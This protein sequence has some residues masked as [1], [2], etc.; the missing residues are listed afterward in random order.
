M[1]RW[2]RGGERGWYG[3]ERGGVGWVGNE[4]GN[5]NGDGET[6]CSRS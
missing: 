3:E 6:Y 2:G 1:V 4:H 5:G